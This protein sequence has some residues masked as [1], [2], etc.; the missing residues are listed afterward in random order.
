MDKKPEQVICTS[1]L[2]GVNQLCAKFT[3]KKR[4]FLVQPKWS[5]DQIKRKLRNIAF[6]ALFE[7]IK[8]VSRRKQEER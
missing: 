4:A 2:D 5:Y 8:E 3:T 1:V 6:N 7:T